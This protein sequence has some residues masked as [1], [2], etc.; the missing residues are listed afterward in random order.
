LNQCSETVYNGHKKTAADDLD[1]AVCIFEL[2]K[3]VFLK[4]VKGDIFGRI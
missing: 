1:I 2:K 4:E 3:K